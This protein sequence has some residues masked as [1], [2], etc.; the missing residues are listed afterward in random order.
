[1]DRISHGVDF[2][3]TPIGAITADL[4]MPRVGDDPLARGARRRRG[5]RMIDRRERPSSIVA[6][7]RNL[8]TRIREK[9][10]ATSP[11]SRSAAQA[12][13]PDCAGR[14][15]DRARR[16]GARLTRAREMRAI[17]LTRAV[18]QAYPVA[19]AEASASAAC[20]RSG[21]AFVTE[22]AP[23]RIRTSMT[24]RPQLAKRC[25][26]KAGLGPAA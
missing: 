4:S 7:N 16:V 26:Q 3:T 8:R 6:P 17:G 22:F 19:R 11:S 15:A 23:H 1:M 13:Q 18:V 10:M 25:T 21:T 5:G 12:A 2:D 9:E 20:C 24:A 14:S